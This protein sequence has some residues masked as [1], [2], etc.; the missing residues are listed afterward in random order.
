M[1]FVIPDFY[2]AAAELFVVAMSFVVLMTG[3]FLQNSRSL[4]YYLTQ[5]TL[6]GA[7][8]VTVHHGR[9]GYAHIHQHVC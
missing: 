7:A 5:F 1:N 9:A 2:P 4:S 8:V 3:T 6:L